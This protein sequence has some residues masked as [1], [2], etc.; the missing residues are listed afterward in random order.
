MGYKLKRI[1]MRPNGVE[2]Q[3]RPTW[4]Q[5]WAN[6]VAYYPLD[7][8]FNDATTNERNLTNT[9]ATITTFNWVSCAYYDGSSYSRYNSSYSLPNTWR[10]VSMWLYIPSAWGCACHVSNITSSGPRPAGLWIVWSSSNYG[11]V[12]WMSTYIEANYTWWPRWINLI[13]TQEWS[14]V[15]MYVDWQYS[16]QSTSRATTWSWYPAEWW[17]IWWTNKPTPDN[18][19][20]WYISRVIL[21]DKART[22]QEVLDY[23]NLTKSNYWL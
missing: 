21:E 17:M 15:K 23:Y 8:D 11:V 22:A 19:F 9:W 7:I 3:V 16:V 1:M 5:P 12:T 4:W 14:I 20:T 10:T 2:K 18:L 6:T 13:C